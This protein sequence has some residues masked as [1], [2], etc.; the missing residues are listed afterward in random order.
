MQP[1]ELQRKVSAK[2]LVNQKNQPPELQRKVS[3]KP[4]YTD[5]GNLNADLPKVADLKKFQV[6]AL[7]SPEIAYLNTLADTFLCS[8]GERL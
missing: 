3:A 2:V 4:L 7:D 6:N 8:S 1:P 5:K